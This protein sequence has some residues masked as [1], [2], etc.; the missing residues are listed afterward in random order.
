MPVQWYYQ[1]QGDSVGPITVA[2]LTYLI[3]RGT[4]TDRTLVRRGWD[5]EWLALDEIAGLL[6]TTGEPDDADGS[7]PTTTE[8]YFNLKSRTKQGP[9]PWSVLKAMTAGGELQPDDL[10]WKPGMALWAP[11]SQVRGLV[12]ESSAITDEQPRLQ[13]RLGS[14]V[15]RVGAAVIVL[16]GLMAAAA[17]WKWVHIGS[18][19][20]AGGVAKRAPGAT[21]KTVA[22]G[23]LGDRA[24]EQLLEDARSAVRVEQLERATRLLEQYLASRLARQSDAAK[25]LLSEITLAR[26]V[27]EAARIAKDLRDEAL[28]DYLQNG[29]DT[30]VAAIVTAEL[31]PIYERTLLQA[32]RHENNRRQMIPRGMIAQNPGPAE[33]NP[34]ANDKEAERAVAIAPH[35]PVEQ[36]RL[37][38][39][40]Q[41]EGAVR[42]AGGNPDPQKNDVRLPR[43][44]GPIPADL[45]HVLAKPGAFAGNSL[46]LNGLF[47]IG[48][49]ITEIKV[50]DGQVLGWSLPVARND[51]STVCSVDG[52]VGRENAY[53]LLDDRLAT[54]LDHVFNKL[55]VRPTIKPTYKCILTVMT[56]RLLVNGVLTSVVVISSMEVLGGCNYVSVARHQYSQ[57]F[58][59]LIVTAEEANVDFGDGNLWVERLGGEENFV[60]PIRRKFRDMQHR[61]IT[62]RDSAVIDSIIQ[63]ELVKVVNTASAIN[64]IVAMEGLRR[65][66]I[67]P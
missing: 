2:E 24:V 63:R 58:R 51:D 23:G 21:E 65:M 61:A 6:G 5:G 46:I 55:K 42:G 44:P 52:K 8:W 10:V 28:K 7:V 25:V 14:R 11:A 20:L 37:S 30:L 47:K 26:S 38:I 41:P 45:E 57:A 34:V 16:L 66:R 27:S 40:G 48:T 54:L 31:R 43:R 56:R 9:V 17:G 36:P 33:A 39:L 59:T 35:G 64:Q 49:K 1:N 53:L 19:D 4:L 29:V 32:F 22:N 50:P 13:N 3:N 15:H 18:R 12:E 60:K 67:W 62:N